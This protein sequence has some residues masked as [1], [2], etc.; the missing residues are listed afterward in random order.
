MVTAHASCSSHVTTV[1]RCR[2]RDSKLF[3]GI[4][5]IRPEVPS[6]RAHQHPP[7]IVPGEFLAVD[8]DDCHMSIVRLALD[9]PAHGA[10]DDP[11]LTKINVPDG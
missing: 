8:H 5:D 2:P 7:R 9:A 6:F 1:L 10:V 4:S 3:A 11:A